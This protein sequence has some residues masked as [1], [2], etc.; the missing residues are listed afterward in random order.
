MGVGSRL[1]QS[2]FHLPRKIARGTRMRCFKT[3]LEAL[4]SFMM[5][6]ELSDY[7]RCVARDVRERYVE[8]ISKINFEDPYLINMVNTVSDDG[9]PSIMYPDIVNYLLF[10]P[11]P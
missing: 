10:A 3:V 11:S 6:V 1:Y 9:H 8:K 4:D 7:A 2:Y 5:G